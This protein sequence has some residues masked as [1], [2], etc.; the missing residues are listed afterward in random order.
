[1]R[2]ARRLRALD[3]RERGR[4]RRGGRRE[5]ERAGD[6]DGAA[7]GVGLVLDLPEDDE[8]QLEDARRALPGELGR[9]A[10]PERH[11]R[12]LGRR[13]QA[14]DLH[15]QRAD[16]VPRRA[17]QAGA[18]E[19]AAAEAELG[20]E[21]AAAPDGHRPVVVVKRDADGEV[22]GD[23]GAGAGAGAVDAAGG[24]GRGEGEAAE[25]GVV[26]GEADG[27]DEGVRD[28]EQCDEGERGE[29][30]AAA[31]HGGRAAGAGAGVGV[32][33]VGAAAHDGAVPAVQVVVIHQ[34]RRP[35][36]MLLQTELA[37]S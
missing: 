36:P 18:R 4:R 13:G 37:A 24:R 32:V 19:R 10:G 3:P 17:G 15:P 5:P 27:D 34:A 1:M 16:P 14:V 28:D 25:G 22:V 33:G 35:H 11:G 26:D 20:V 2:A 12:A 21:G 23:G 9:R 8:L 30:E 6:P 31:E 29:E 7:A